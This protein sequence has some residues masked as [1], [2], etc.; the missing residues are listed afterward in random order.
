MT[1]LQRFRLLRIALV[2]CGAAILLICASISYGQTANYALK[3]GDGRDVSDTDLKRPTVAGLT[4]RVPW[5]VLNPRPGIYNFT[6]IDQN[7]AQAQ[8]CGNKPVKL[9]V[10]T[11]RGGASP[12]W[13]GGLSYQGAPLPWSLEMLTA[14]D[15]LMQ[16]LGRKYRYRFYTVHITGPTYPSAEMHPAP[17]IDRVRGYSDAKMVDAWTTAAQSVANAFP[18]SAVALSISVQQP[19][20]RY[21]DATINKIRTHVG[22][23]L[24]IQHNALKANTN[25]TAAH[26]RLLLKYRAL[27]V[28]IGFEMACSATNEPTR[29]GSRDVMQGVKLGRE[30]GAEWC[31]IYP[32]DIK[33]LK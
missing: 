13:F 20:G 30:A 24:I 3:P 6:E 12:S 11:G 9:I 29:F 21:V 14:Y 10:Q 15:T 32:P 28:R 1:N 19:A 33:N 23:R 22:S 7:L 25:V 8:R 2:V 16:E 26:H 31:D 18:G 5:S 27:G 4:I 17:G